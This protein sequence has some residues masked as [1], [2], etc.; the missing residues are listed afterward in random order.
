MQVTLFLQNNQMPIFLLPVYTDSSHIYK[1]EIQFFHWFCKFY[2]QFC[3][4]TLSKFNKLYSLL[5]KISY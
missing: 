1:F 5:D 4:P 3:E 2:V